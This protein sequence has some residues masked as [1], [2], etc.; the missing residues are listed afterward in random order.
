MT[1]G[2]HQLAGLAGCAPSSCPNPDQASALFHKRDMLQDDDL[3]QAATAL[4]RAAPLSTSLPGAWH[5][6]SYHHQHPD[7]T[8]QSMGGTSHHGQHFPSRPQHSLHLASASMSTENGSFCH[9]SLLALRDLAIRDVPPSLT[10]SYIPDRSGHSWRDGLVSEYA[11]S[12]G[13]DDEE[14]EDDENLIF[15]YEDWRNR[16]S[17]LSSGKG[18]VGERTCPSPEG[19]E[20]AVGAR[21]GM[22]IPSGRPRSHSDLSLPASQE[23]RRRVWN[24][25]LAEELFEANIWPGS[26]GLGTPGSDWV[27]TSCTASSA[28]SCASSTIASAKPPTSMPRVT[29][30][31]YVPGPS[32]PAPPVVLSRKKR[33]STGPPAGGAS[34]RSKSGP[35][36]PSS[37]LPKCLEAEA[38][39][40]IRGVAERCCDFCGKIALFV[41]AIKWWVVKI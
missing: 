35:A 3:L 10:R 15:P 21:G 39:P 32:P 12:D 11:L 17:G 4:V 1:Q 36:T 23:D 30:N 26:G 9:D 28:V 16:R 34:P 31:V 20:E 22:T 38:V 41:C 37:S 7:T 40:P 24:E 27:A 19:C 18:G 25:Q 6:F 13:A 14:D 33:Q 5:D 29:T 2:A 8:G